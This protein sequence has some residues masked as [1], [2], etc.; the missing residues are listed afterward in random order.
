M[1]AT[2]LGADIDKRRAAQLLDDACQAGN[3]D[4]CT[5]LERMWH[6]ASDADVDAPGS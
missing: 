1:H 4:A 6:R 5:M 2:G 3:D